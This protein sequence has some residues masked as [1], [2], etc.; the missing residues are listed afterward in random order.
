MHPLPAGVVH[1]FSEPVPVHPVRS[2]L[3][4]QQHRHEPVPCM[5]RRILLF[6]RGVVM[7]AVRP[8]HV[9][10]PGRGRPIV[11]SMPQGFLHCCQWD[12]CV[13]QL[14]PW[15]VHAIRIV[16]EDRAVC[17]SVTQARK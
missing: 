9:F 2:W 12:G 15:D 3:L 14:S 17:S 8:G 5:P 13:L 10:T 4:R 7:H 1:V 6:S 16:T 11:H